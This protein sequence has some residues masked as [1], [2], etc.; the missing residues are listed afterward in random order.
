MSLQPYTAPALRVLSLGAGVQ[1]STLLVLAVDRALPRYDAAVFADTGWEPAEVYAHLRRLEQLA[2]TADIPVLRVRAGD[3]RRDAL[4]PHHRFVSMPLFVLGPGGERGMARRQCTSEYKI[5]PI[6]ATDRALL[7]YPH[8]RRVPKG[9]YVEQAIGISTEEF[10]RA[11]DADVAYLR[12]VFPLIDLGW[13]RADCMAYLTY[14]GLPD[15]PRSACVGCPY[16]SNTEWRRIRDTDPQAWAEA[17][18]FDEAI[19]HG[20]PRGLAAGQPLRGTYYLHHSRRPLAQADLGQDPHVTEPEGCSPWAC[21]SG[22]AVPD[23]DA[24]QRRRP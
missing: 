3:I 17:I 19:R 2:A 20:H 13:T 8:P 22:P 9:V 16:H 24:A 14:R 15:T 7:G 4:D 11:K 23:A 10:H 21:R 12:N 1:S 5:G 18:A 6:K